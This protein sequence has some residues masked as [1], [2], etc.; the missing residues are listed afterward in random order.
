MGKLVRDRI[1]DLIRA[2][3]R[4]PVIRTL[5]SNEYLAALLDKLVEEAGE[6]RA[7]EP[8]H[9][10]AELADVHEVLRALTAH[11]GIHPEDVTAAA[12]CKR[13]ER[14]GFDDRLWLA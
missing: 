1:P 3:G 2:D 12:E 7:A 11:L 13:I 9:R 8:E 10:L 6:L 4:V 5:D 14:G